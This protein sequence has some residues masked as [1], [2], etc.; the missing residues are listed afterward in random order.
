MKTLILINPVAGN[1]KAAHIWPELSRE[2]QF[3]NPFEVIYSQ[4]AGHITELVREALR[5][6]VS[7]ILMVGGDGSLTEATNGYFDEGKVINPSAIVGT[8]PLGTGSDFLK[9]WGI[10][11]IRMS[12]IGLKKNRTVLCDVGQVTYQDQKQKKQAKLFLNVA[13]FGCA[14][15]I[16]NRVSHSHKMWGAKLT[17]LKAMVTTFLTYHHPTIDMTADSNKKRSVVINNVFICNGKYSGGGMCWGPNASVIDGLLDVTIVKE[18]PKIQGILNMKKIY[19]GQVLSLKEVEGMKCQRLTAESNEEVPLEVDG[20]VVGTLPATFQ[21][22]PQ[23]INFW[24]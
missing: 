2:V 21:M 14:G 19:N 12:L 5:R 15:E 22:F 1:G 17:Y 13:S 11:N 7:R 6:G 24:Y 4:K 8:L 3:L 10:K 16:I 9:T 20:D 23:K 18:I